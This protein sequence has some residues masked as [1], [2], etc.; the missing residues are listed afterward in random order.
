MY[1]T[2]TQR[3]D[4]MW[5]FKKDITYMSIRMFTKILKVFISRFGF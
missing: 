2:D 4:E 5:C 3:S 1:V